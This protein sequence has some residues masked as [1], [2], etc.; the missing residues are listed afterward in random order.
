MQVQLDVEGPYSPG[1]SKASILYNR[2][3][4]GQRAVFVAGGTAIVEALSVL[5]RSQAQPCP[6]P[7]PWHVIWVCRSQGLVQATKPALARLVATIGLRVDIFFP[8]DGSSKPMIPQA[9]HWLSVRARH[10]S[11]GP[12]CIPL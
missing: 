1:D 2:A 10:Q 3:A 9:S 12:F 8:D 7:A 11:L 6:S 5:E 4:S